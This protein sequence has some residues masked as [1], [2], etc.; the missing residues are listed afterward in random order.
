MQTS[1]GK[2]FQPGEEQGQSPYRRINLSIQGITG[3]PV[4][5]I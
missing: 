5:S 2:A 3:S 4:T 1:G